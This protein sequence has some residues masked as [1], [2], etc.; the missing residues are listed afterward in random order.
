[1]S[2]ELFREVD[3]EVRQEQYHKL[4][5]RYG[6]Y[7][8]GVAIAIVAG[9]IAIVVWRDMQETAR[10]DDSTRFIAAAAQE[11]VTPE[12][13]IAA[14]RELARD[15]T[16]GYRFLASLRE[17]RL[18]AD[19]GDVSQAVAAFD[20]AAADDAL[21]ATYRDLA[22]LLAVSNGMGV[23]S[24][25]EVE[26][27]IAAIDAPDN[28]FRFSARELLAVAAIQAGARER[29]GDLL[30]ANLEDPAAPP[31]MRARATELLAAI[32]LS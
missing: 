19:A 1:V 9:T 27:R 6:V 28:P 23:L 29:A 14:L 31:A 24:M 21:D 30:R 17:A 32:G 20:A 4:W 8:A 15:G 7:I 25:A 10:Q 3:E 11:Q 22:R 2:D 26:Q 18:L 12:A 13:A 16:T 5:K